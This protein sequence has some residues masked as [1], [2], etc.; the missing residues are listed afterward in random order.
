MKSK[1]EF[2]GDLMNSMFGSDVILMLT[3]R[4]NQGTNWQ[5]SAVKE[6]SQDTQLT[7]S[8]YHK[9]YHTSY[10]TQPSPTWDL[11]HN[12]VET[13]HDVRWPLK[14]SRALS[15][16]PTYDVEEWGQNWT[17]PHTNL[18]TAGGSSLIVCFHDRGDLDPTLLWLVS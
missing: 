18:A 5:F 9:S 17:L 1:S 8:Y 6:Y 11:R 14:Q 15:V 13:D 3:G 2:S 10:L 12:P 4:Y 16:P 7:T